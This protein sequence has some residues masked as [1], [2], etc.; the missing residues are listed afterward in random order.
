MRSRRPGTGGL[1]IIASLVCRGRLPDEGL[2]RAG[3]E[4]VWQHRGAGRRHD[5]HPNA[6][7]ARSITGHDSRHGQ[8]PLVDVIIEP[9]RN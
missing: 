5:C 4:H 7:S 1:H 8:H 3:P 6:G 2:A 9:E